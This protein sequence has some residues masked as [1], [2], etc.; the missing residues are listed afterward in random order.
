MLK[1]IFCLL[2]LFTLSLCMFSYSFAA[3]EQFSVVTGLTGGTMYAVS[4]GWAD[5]VNKTIPDINI[6][7]QEGGGNIYTARV[8]SNKEA[9]FA[10]FANDTAYYLY[11]GLQDFEGH[12]LPALRAIT[13][14]YTESFHG[15]T[16][17]NSDIYKFEDLI[18][19]KTGIGP[20]GSGTLVINKRIIEA[21]GLK[22]EEIGAMNLGF[23]DAADYLRDEHVDAILY[24]TG[25][26]FSPVVD[27]STTKPVRIFGISN[28]AIDKLIEKYPFYIHMTVPVIDAYR[29]MD[30]PIE[31]VSVKML[32]LTRIDIEEEKI[33]KVT[34]A[35]FENI[36]NIRQ[37][38][39]SMSNFKV[40]TALDG[41]PVP[42]HPGAERYY[43]EIGLIK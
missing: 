20:P 13:G 2:F 6:T 18:G 39:A 24:T 4:A 43:K 35:F 23:N 21:Y 31:T 15:V 36:E 25:L 1:K 42:L 27:V 10:L 14:L 40:D 19:K 34:K 9:E 12:E 28:E 30:E 8:L 33:Y 17:K 38:H 22:E 11:N 41:I 26:P 5:V 7:N 3:Q 37:S 29:G 16:L 32:L